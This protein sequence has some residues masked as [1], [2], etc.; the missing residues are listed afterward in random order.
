MPFI[1]TWWKKVP[2]EQR[3]GEINDGPEIVETDT[4]VPFKE[5]IAQIQAAG[6]MRVELL[7]A[8]F[9]YDEATEPDPDVVVDPTTEPGYDPSMITEAIHA[10]STRMEDP[11]L[12]ETPGDMGD[13][14]PR[15]PD[16]GGEAPAA[17][18]AGTTGETPK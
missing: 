15:V 8:R 17:A 3:P 7:R 16:P 12:E 4:Y 10:E 13:P 5:Q 11:V 9:H 14:D 18:D 6:E 2:L 1:Q